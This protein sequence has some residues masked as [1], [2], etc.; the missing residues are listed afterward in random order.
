MSGCEFGTFSWEG[1]LCQAESLAPSVGSPVQAVSL[2]HQ[3]GLCVRPIYVVS[4]VREGCPISAD[5]KRFPKM[6]NY[7]RVTERVIFYSAET[8]KRLQI[9]LST[10]S[11]SKDGFT[12]DM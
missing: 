7:V 8:C 5:D 2:V 12:D 1:A 11:T 6:I 3:F 4:H 10:Y 9:G